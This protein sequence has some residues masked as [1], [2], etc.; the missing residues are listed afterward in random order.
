LSQA[1]RANITFRTNIEQLEYKLRNFKD[2]PWEW[3]DVAGARA[4]VAEL[5]M[6][7]KLK[8]RIDRQRVRHW[9]LAQERPMSDSNQAS[10]HPCRAAAG[11]TADSEKSFVHIS[12][13]FEMRPNEI[14]SVVPALEMNSEI[15][16]S[17]LA[18]VPIA[19]SAINEETE[20]LEIVNSAFRA[21]FLG[22]LKRY[23]ALRKEEHDLREGNSPL[24]EQP[25]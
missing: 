16:S 14:Q 25:L 18:N 2:L 3:I 23:S 5:K 19:V 6:L 9:L 17:A 8:K 7:K 20:E 4:K 1:F 11:F 22:D 21:A 10:G 13:S 12:S 24:L 15:T